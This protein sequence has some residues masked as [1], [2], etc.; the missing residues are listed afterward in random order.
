VS[1]I[2]RQVLNTKCLQAEIM[3]SPELM[4]SPKL[5]VIDESD[6]EEYPNNQDVVSAKQESCATI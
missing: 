2:V 4:G 1:R 3:G 5:T 6:L